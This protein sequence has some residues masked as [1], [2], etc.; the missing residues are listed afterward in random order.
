MSPVVRASGK[1]VSLVVDWS[2]S[3]VLVWFGF[4]LVYYGVGR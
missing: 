4:D 1:E 2:V 3:C